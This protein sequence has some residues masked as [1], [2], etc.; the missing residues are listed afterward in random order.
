MAGECHASIESAE[1]NNQ[2][3]DI[4]LELYGQV[5]EGLPKKGA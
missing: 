3:Q 2:L 5:P 4:R 1:D